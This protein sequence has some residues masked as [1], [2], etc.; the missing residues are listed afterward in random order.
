MNDTLWIVD[1]LGMSVANAGP[2]TQ[3]MCTVDRLKRRIT[4]LENRG[5]QLKSEKE[6]LKVIYSIWIT[7]I[8]S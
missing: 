7:L 2:N 4:H 6:Q 5:Q 8:I 1:G 3:H